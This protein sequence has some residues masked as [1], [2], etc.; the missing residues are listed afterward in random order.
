M[1]RCKKECVRDFP[2]DPV[3]KTLPSNAGGEGS[4]PGQ[5]GKIPYASLPK[6]QRW[7]RSNI[8]TN[9]IKSFKMCVCVSHSVVSDSASPWIIVHQAP[10][11]LEF[12]R[13]EYW[14]R[15]LCPSPG[16]HPVP[17]LEPRSPALQTDSLSHLGRPFELPGSFL[18]VHVKISK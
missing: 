11:S 5:G 17:G 10:L 6:N 14:S 2:G 8:V 18:M 13:Q 1:R 4:I 12:S 15:L 16:D 3:V 9:S 7:N